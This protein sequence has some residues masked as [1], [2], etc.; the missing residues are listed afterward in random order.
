M[1]WASKPPR[2]RSKQ[3]PCANP[4]PRVASSV[5]KNGKRDG[6][7]AAG[8]L[9]GKQA[10]GRRGKTVGGDRKPQPR[11]KLKRRAYEAQL[12]RLQHELVKLQ[13]YVRQEGL[14]VVVIFE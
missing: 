11:K 6:E 1:V 3:D 13:E 8:E 7:S 10:R 12:E 2:D 9:N 4:R 14:R 5:A